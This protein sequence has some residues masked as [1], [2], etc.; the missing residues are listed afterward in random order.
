MKRIV[1]IGPGDIEFHYHKLLKINK[2]KLQKEI[3]ALAKSLYSSN[4]ELALLPDRG[5][6][7]EIAKEFKRLGGKVLG[8]V[9]LSD[10]F[11]GVSFLKSYMETQVNGE[12]LFSSFIDTGDWPKQDLN[13]GL[14]GDAV[15]FLGKSPGTEGERNYA[16]YMYKI[17]SRMKDGVSQGIETIHKEARAGKNITFTIFAYQP[18]LHNKKFSKEDEVYAKKF[19]INLVYIKNTKDLEKNLK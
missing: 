19:G 9:P 12:S 17:I 1:L 16:V 8:L 7:L 2:E 4:L 6:S 11:P 5:I 14:Y 15:L 18:F 13:M 3:M 10:K